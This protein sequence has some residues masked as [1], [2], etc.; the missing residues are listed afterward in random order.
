MVQLAQKPHSN[1]AFTWEDL[2]TL[3]RDELQEYGGLVGLL[4]AQQQSILDRRTESLMEINQKFQVEMPILSA[5]YS[6]LYQGS[7]CQRK[8]K[9]LTSKLS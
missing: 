1:L 4:S 6:V 2:L 9:E 5:V 7:N 3:L 8:M